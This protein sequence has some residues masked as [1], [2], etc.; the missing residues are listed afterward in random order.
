MYHN[1]QGHGAGGLP[2]VR[3]EDGRF[4]RH[5]EVRGVVWLRYGA[6]VRSTFPK[7]SSNTMNSDVISIVGGQTLYPMWCSLFGPHKADIRECRMYSSDSI[8]NLD[9]P[10]AL[11]SG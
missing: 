1:L 3:C 6:I 5:S 4:R 10:I 2:A 11:I 7:L 8:D 9:Q